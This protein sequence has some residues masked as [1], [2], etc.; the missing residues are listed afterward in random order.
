M[1]IWPVYT[2]TI[3]AYLNDNQSSKQLNDTAEI[4][5]AQYE[6]TVRSGSTIFQN[7]VIA[8]PGYQQIKAGFSVAFQQMQNNNN[9][10]PSYFTPAASAI[11]SFWQSVVFNPLP[12]AP[13]TS[14]PAPGVQVLFAGDTALLQAGLFNAFNTPPAAQPL[15][16]V[17]AGKLT[18]A[19]STHV[20]TISGIYIGLSVAIPF[21]P[22]AVPWVGII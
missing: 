22:I 3:A 1:I 12:P 8:T 7:F 19:F 17:V 13:G 4:I 18:S 6:S 20:S 10:L 21:P 15:G 9:I 2:N 16:S 5:A 14:A 11:V